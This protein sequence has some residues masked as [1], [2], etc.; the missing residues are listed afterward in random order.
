MTDL[1]QQDDTP[2]DDA[3]SDAESFPAGFPDEESAADASQSADASQG[4]EWADDNQP[5]EPPPSPILAKLALV[6]PVVAG[7]IQAF[8]PD[9]AG[10]AVVIGTILLTAVLLAID[11]GSVVR[12]NPHG[13]FSASPTRTLFGIILLWIV[14]FP[15]TYFRRIAICG[16]DMRGT[17]VGAVAAFLFLPSLIT[18]WLK[19]PE[20]PA[21]DSQEVARV[22]Q[23]L[24]GR[25]FPGRRV[26]GVI[27]LREVVADLNLQQRRGSCTVLVDDERIPVP[28]KVEW[29]DQKRGIFL[30]ALL[31]LPQA[32]SPAVIELVEPQVRRQLEEFAITGIDD[33]REVEFDQQNQQRECT[34][35]VHTES[36]DIVVPFA[37]RWHSR[38]RVEY[39]VR[40]FV[41]PGPKSQEIRDALQELLEEAFADLKITSIDG[42]REIRADWERGERIGACTVHLEQEDVEVRFRIKWSDRDLGM[43][44]LELIEEDAV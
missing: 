40:S 27:D 15:L 24:A 25:E 1:P 4:E 14:F 2:A 10:L 33:F 5:S 39:V 44:S 13:Q 17:A 12:W 6:L 38:E 16:P 32:N 28:Y 11:I 3:F 20:L 21:C 18:A 31:L 22:I 23:Q 37:V 42:Y 30:V 34:C 36:G 29:N 43:F 41:V 35:V 26:K 7:I 9:A 19:P 8:L